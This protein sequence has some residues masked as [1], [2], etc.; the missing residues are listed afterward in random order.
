MHQ[1]SRSDLFNV[2][3]KMKQTRI[4]DKW[5]IGSKDAK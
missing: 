4:Y 2:N 1:G 5:I 3:L